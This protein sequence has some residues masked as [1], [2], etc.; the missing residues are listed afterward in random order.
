M[1]DFYRVLV[2]DGK[3]MNRRW[4]FLC[5]SHHLCL[6]TEVCFGCSRP[7]WCEEKGAGVFAVPFKWNRPRFQCHWLPAVFFFPRVCQQVCK[8][9]M[10]LWLHWTCCHNPCE[11]RAFSVKNRQAFMIFLKCVDYVD[12]LSCLCLLTWP[13]KNVLRAFTVTKTVLQLS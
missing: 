1:L 4:G 10:S 11:S 5:S 7:S 9:G 8:G 3:L 12:A 2:P 6:L 13:L